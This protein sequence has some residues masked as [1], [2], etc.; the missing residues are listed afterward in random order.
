MKLKPIDRTIENPEHKGKH[1]E[2]TKCGEH[3]VAYEILSGRYTCFMRLCGAS[4][5]SG[6]NQYSLGAASC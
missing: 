1:L 5:L 3:S 6:Y 4:E 2:C